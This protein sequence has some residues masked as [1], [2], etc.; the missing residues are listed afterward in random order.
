MMDIANLM[1]KVADADMSAGGVYLLPGDYRLKVRECKN[2]EAKN[3]GFPFFVVEFEVLESTEPKRPAGSITEWMV[4]FKE[5]KYEATYLGNVKNFL[6]AV[7]AGFDPNATPEK[8]NAQVWA[9]CV[10]EQQPLRDR[11]VAA[12]SVDKAKKNS[13]GSFTRT[14][15]SPWAGPGV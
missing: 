3:A 5:P 11:Y 4:A 6:W 1:G 12:Q 15:F 2:G 13:P 10:S 7:F 9:L 14:T 8:I